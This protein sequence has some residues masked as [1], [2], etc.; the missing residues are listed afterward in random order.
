MKKIITVIL[1]IL[2]VCSMAVY[3]QS[4]TENEGE[5]K[6]RDVVFK[7][8]DGE[9]MDRLE[10][11]TVFVSPTVSF[12]NYYH[13]A[14]DLG[15]CEVALLSALYEG[16]RIKECYFGEKTIY[17]GNNTLVI[18]TKFTV[19]NPDTQKIS[20]FV[21]DGVTFEPYCDEVT[22]ESKSRKAEIEA[23][24]I[25]G[26]AADINGER[27]IIWVENAEGTDT[28]VIES[29]EVAVSD[30]ASYSKKNT[31]DT[32]INGEKISVIA[33]NGTKREYIVKIE[34]EQSVWSNTN[35]QNNT[36]DANG[37]PDR[38]NVAAYWDNT[39]VTSSQSASINN[40]GDNKF[41]SYYTG[42]KN[43]Q[44]AQNCYSSA[45]NS[46]KSKITFSFDFKV[47]RI[48]NSQA[49]FP[50]YLGSGASSILMFTNYNTRPC[51]DGVL[52]EKYASKYQIAYSY[53]RNSAARGANIKTLD[54]GKWYNIK[55]VQRYISDEDALIECYVNGEML[56][57]T[58]YW[59]GHSMVYNK[60]HASGVERKTFS[61]NIY[62]DASA[63]ADVN[64]YAGK[65][66]L[67]FKPVYTPTISFD[68]DNIQVS[69]AQ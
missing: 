31:G 32:L 56:F 33:E 42:G 12:E 60:Q 48:D 50:V 24:T 7:N 22:L 49:A 37:I 4:Y 65:N 11:G 55:L 29:I 16:N 52:A 38:T 67:V 59:L 15:K 9:E 44:I 51:D 68:L 27:N 61:T 6:I 20:V 66:F 40:D 10:A 25:N 3:A 43:Y 30:G 2:I 14:D 28:E 69:Y 17:G 13:Y 54:V 19:T 45:L 5:I 36:L 62:A 26:K 39:N 58:P 34:G 18:D 63:A 35:F 47:N 21:W 1:T 8:A 64:G 53:S 41:L 23:F 57:D 46:N